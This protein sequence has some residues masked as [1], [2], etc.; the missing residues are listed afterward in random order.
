MVL[1]RAAFPFWCCCGSANAVPALCRFGEDVM[2]TMVD[3]LDVFL[4]QQKL[5]KQSVRILDVGTGN[6]V[7]LL[8]LAKLGFQNLTG[9][10]YSAQ[11][12]A[13]AN[14]ILQQHQ[15]TNVKLVVRSLQLVAKAF[16]RFPQVVLTHL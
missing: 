8:Q 10:D 7:L 11:S 16:R 9:S 12:I 13:L 3:W 6:G 14:K 15:A 5:D 1:S 2:H 4:K